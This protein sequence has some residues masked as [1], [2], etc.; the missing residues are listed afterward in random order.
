MIQQVTID[1][2]RGFHGFSCDE[3]SPITVIGGRNNSGKSSLL[4]ALSL[5]FD[6]STAAGLDR[7][8]GFRGVR[9]KSLS[10]FSSF[11][12]NGDMSRAVRIECMFTDGYRRSVEVSHKLSPTALTLSE[13]GAPMPVSDLKSSVESLERIEVKFSVR[14]GTE[15]IAEFEDSAYVVAQGATDVSFTRVDKAP[16]SVG[17]YV[18]A[19]CRSMEDERLEQLYLAN[20]FDLIKETVRKIDSRIVDLAPVDHRLMARVV[21]VDKMLPLRVMG[22]GMVKTVACLAMILSVSNGGVCAFD[23]IENGLHYS[24]MQS[25]WHTLVEVARA[26]GVQLVV[27]THSLEFLQAISRVVEKIGSDDF[28][29]LK[30]SR[31]QGGDTFVDRYSGD[32]FRAYI[33][34]EFELR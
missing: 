27:T 24:A 20:Q 15:S 18:A 10:D 13:P 1:G 29:Y 3:L 4:E 14:R 25:V 16:P 9:S 2:F 19:A 6:F 21:G 23:E 8:N 28:A 17:E 26:R 12:A 5:V 32:E 31:S 22:D 34:Q 30:M 7:L 11:F 33:D